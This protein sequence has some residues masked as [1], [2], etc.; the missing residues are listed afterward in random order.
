MRGSEGHAVVT[1]DV[2][3]QAAL[4]KKPLKHSESVIFP[5]R[6][7]RFTSKQKT[8]GVISDGERITVL[9]IGKQELA[10]VIGT[11]ELIGPLSQRQGVPWARRRTRPRR[12]T[13]PWRSST[14]WMVLL[15]GIGIPENLRS[16]RSRIL[17]APQL[18]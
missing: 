7:K 8:A 9:A 16:K 12:S 3:G 10:L 14:A 11:P 15:A 2:G 1:A 6:G 5:G 17:R 18:E 4:L 13:R